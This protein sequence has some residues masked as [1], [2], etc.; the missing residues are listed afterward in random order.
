[1]DAFE[2]S[3][4]MSNILDSATFLNLKSY[5]TLSR[6]SERSCLKSSMS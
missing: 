2:S 1:M 6:N 4:R 3:H 5:P